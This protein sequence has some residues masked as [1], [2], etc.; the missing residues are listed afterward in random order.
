MKKPT[1]ILFAPF[2]L[3][4]W[5]VI[6]PAG[7][8]AADNQAHAHHH[9]EHGSEQ[10]L[11][12]NAGKKWASDASLRRNMNA[13]NQAMR[14]ALPKIHAD[15]FSDNDYQMLATRIEKNVSDAVEQCKLDPAAD[16]MLHL[17]IA[18]LM[19]GT[20]ALAG[21]SSLSRHDGAVRVLNALNSYG[22]YFQHP[23]WKTAA[24]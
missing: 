14:S 19:A 24:H 6:A 11:Q 18:E 1:I 20:E 8:T 12:L 23:H 22:K 2:S 5:L 7:A 9:H 17:V 3:A 4:L 16:A 10:Q 13:I 21:K 15:R